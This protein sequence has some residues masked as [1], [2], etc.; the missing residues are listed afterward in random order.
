M[1]DS[2]V[3]TAQP[4]R[5]VEITLAA[6]Q[7]YGNGYTDVDVW[8]DFTHDDGTILRR[9]AFWDGGCT[10][11][12]RFASPRDDGRWT[13][14]AFSSVV[15]AGLSGPTGVVVCAA[16]E[17]PANRFHRHGFWRMSPGGRNYA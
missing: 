10:W 13:W 3:I 4:W 12:I 11:R 16:G 14:R 15:D 5:E 7:E 1:T 17:T 6:A 8:A 9:P 2:T